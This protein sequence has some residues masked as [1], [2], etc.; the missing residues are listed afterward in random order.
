MTANIKRDTD[1]LFVWNDNFR[2]NVYPHAL[3]DLLNK[4][5][6]RLLLVADMNNSKQGIDMLK[7]EVET[8]GL[9]GFFAPKGALVGLQQTRDGT[10][11]WRWGNCITCGGK[12]PHVS[13]YSFC[14][15]EAGPPPPPPL[16]SFEH[17]N[18]LR[19]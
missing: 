4:R 5:N 12:F 11:F 13:A 10:S 3:D 17:G 1:V 15:T 19:L 6:C 2:R 16:Y 14:F 18:Y 9:G 7:Q 8:F